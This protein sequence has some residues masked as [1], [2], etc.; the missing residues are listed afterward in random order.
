MAKNMKRKSP[1]RIDRLKIAELISGH[2][3]KTNRLPQP[4]DAGAITRAYMGSLDKRKRNPRRQSVYNLVRTMLTPQPEADVPTLKVN[5]SPYTTRVKKPFNGPFD[6]IPP[7][8]DK[9]AE[10]K[11]QA[12]DHLY[13]P[14]I[15]NL[16]SRIAHHEHVIADLKNALRLIIKHK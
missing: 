13:D 2:E 11:A 3:N 9:K 15:I 16:R 6:G 5:D 1:V 7:Y 10:K 4:S 8:E 12:D 14:I